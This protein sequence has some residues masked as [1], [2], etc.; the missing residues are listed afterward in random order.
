MIGPGRIPAWRALLSPLL[1]NPLQQEP[2][3]PTLGYSRIL[4]ISLLVLPP[5]RALCP[6]NVSLSRHFKCVPSPAWPVSHDSQGSFRT[7][8]FPWGLCIYVCVVGGSVVGYGAPK[9]WGIWRSNGS[10]PGQ[11]LGHRTFRRNITSAWN[12]RRSST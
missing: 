5:L 4:K 12:K 2:G 11:I 9:E 7:G 3:V 10:K 6:L 8:S 1:P